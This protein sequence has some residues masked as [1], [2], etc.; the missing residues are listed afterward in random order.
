MLCLL[1]CCLP[2]NPCILLL[3]SLTEVHDTPAHLYMP[4][5]FTQSSILC[6]SL[7]YIWFNIY[8]CFICCLIE[9]A[10]DYLIHVC[11]GPPSFVMFDFEVHC[12]LFQFFVCTW[13]FTYFLFAPDVLHNVFHFLYFYVFLLS[14]CNIMEPLISISQLYADMILL[15]YIMLDVILLCE[16]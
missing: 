8:A 5:L 11:N 2:H 3:T 13:C 6:K 12:L 15:W 14:I 16:Q 4:Q 7:L 9:M 10:W 1:H